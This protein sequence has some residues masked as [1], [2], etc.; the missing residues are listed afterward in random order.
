[1]KNTSEHQVLTVDASIQPLVITPSPEA[2]SYTH[3]WRI[4][5]K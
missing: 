2:V 5:K 4:R 3:L 1:M